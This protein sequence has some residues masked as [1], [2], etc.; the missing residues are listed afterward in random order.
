VGQPATERVA[1][2]DRTGHLRAVHRGAVRGGDDARQAHHRF[3][4]G[5]DDQLRQRAHRRSH[6]AVALA[7][8]SVTASLAPRSN[9]CRSASR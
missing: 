1:V 7:T 8:V 6:E 2:A 9:S 3:G 5:L 4:L